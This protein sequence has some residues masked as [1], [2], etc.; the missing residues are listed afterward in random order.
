LKPEY[1]ASGVVY[2]QQE[3]LLSSLTAV[4]P[5]GFTW[6]TAADASAAELNEL[7]QTDSFVRAIILQ[8]G[9]E[10]SMDM[11][12]DAVSETISEVRES[13]WA[14]STGSNQMLITASNEDSEIAYQIVN[15]AVENHIQW[16]M[17]AARKDSVSAQEFFVD[18]IGKYRLDL[19]AAQ[20]ELDDYLILHPEPIR[21]DRS[22]IETLAIAR[23]QSRVD[24]ATT[25]YSSAL[26]KEEEA[27]LALAQVE[28]VIRQQYFLIDAPIMPEDTETSKKD[29]AVTLAIFMVAGGV[30]ASVGVIGGTLLDRTFRFPIDVEVLLELP[31]LTNIMAPPEVRTR[32]K[33]RRK[34]KENKLEPMI[35]ADS[36]IEL[37]DQVAV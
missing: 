14:Q 34:A 16:Q 33:K 22:E 30:L 21:G 8:T 9:L 24:L 3:S 27:R 12:R 29:L 13:V 4:A 25:R 28:S 37:K 5:D 15:A 36:A 20:Q 1:R 26:D 7:L 19:E 2:V 6:M 23:L 10:K 17:N 32:R 31:V 35:E 18:L 11:G